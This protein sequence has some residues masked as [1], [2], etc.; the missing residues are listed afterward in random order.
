MEK[1]VEQRPLGSQGLKVSCQGLG[2]MGM[3]AFYDTKDTNGQETS[4][5][6]KINTI[7]A[8]LDCG[9]NFID[10]AWIYQNFQTGETNEALVGKA[11]KKYGR[12]KFIV[13][14][15]FGI[16]I[17]IEDG[18]PVRIVSGKSEFIRSQL[19]DSLK[20][21]DTDYIDLY[22]MHRMDPTTPIEET[23]KCLLELQ[24]DGKI[25]YVG[26]SECT[27]DEL[28]RAHKIMPITAVQMEWSLNTRDIEQDIVPT[29]RKLGVGIVAYSPLGRGLLSGTFSSKEELKPTD[30]RFS[31]PKFSGENF[32]I[33]IE[34]SKKL[35]DW[36]KKKGYSVGQIALA[37]VH[38]RGKDV[39]PIPG[40]KSIKR[41]IENAA[42]AH[43][44]LDENEC[45]EI[46]E[47]IG[48]PV[49]E[50]YSEELLKSTYKARLN[51]SDK[52]EC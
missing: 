13:A 41:I 12:E 19:A 44:V 7:G 25:R 30:F 10:T 34:R 40:T 33:N 5:E 45:K 48:E 23:M 9:I 2:T 52:S 27:P 31:Q 26:L 21:L 38:S 42:S 22:Y 6:E 1:T 15:K 14:T 36:A 35:E 32:Q 16:G 18:K 43:I 4:E 49:G 37:W 39:F 51:L 11:L 20:R 17:S 46:E 28:E 24:K 29:A 8:A 50:R 3:T 47:I